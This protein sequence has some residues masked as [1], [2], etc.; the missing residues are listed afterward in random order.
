MTLVCFSAAWKQEFVKHVQEIHDGKQNCD[1]EICKVSFEKESN[2]KLYQKSRQYII[3]KLIRNAPVQ[4][5]SKKKHKKLAHSKR[6]ESTI[7]VSNTISD[8]KDSLINEQIKPY[9]CSI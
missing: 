4:L 2:L 5:K 6:K 9:S 8:H 1:C 3:K 7:D